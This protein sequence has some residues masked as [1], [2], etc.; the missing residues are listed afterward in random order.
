MATGGKGVKSRVAVIS[1]AIS[2]TV[3]RSLYNNITYE[4]NLK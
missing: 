1:G 4:M 2:I 3:S